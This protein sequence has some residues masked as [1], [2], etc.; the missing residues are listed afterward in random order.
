MTTNKGGNM[1]DNS[2][3]ARFDK[4]LDNYAVALYMTYQLLDSGLLEKKI[5]IG[6]DVDK[7]N[8]LVGAF[9]PAL[10]N[11]LRRAEKIKLAIVKNCYDDYANSALDIANACLTELNTYGGEWEN[12]DLVDL[13]TNYKEQAEQ[14]AEAEKW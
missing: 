6:V 10:A 9:V 4:L 14:E 13:F 11:D 7:I 5:K 1:N 8:Q 3:K 12:A 2:K